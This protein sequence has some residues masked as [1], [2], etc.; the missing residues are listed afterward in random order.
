MRKSDTICSSLLID[1]NNQSD[2]DDS[3]RARTVYE[4]EHTF[5]RVVVNRK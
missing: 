2:D 4:C 1:I 5:S 3:G